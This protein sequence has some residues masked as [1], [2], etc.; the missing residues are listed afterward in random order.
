MA[1]KTTQATT[2]AVLK[3]CASAMSLQE[4]SS[5]LHGGVPERTLRRWLASW[6]EADQIVRLGNSRATRYRYQT[7]DVKSFKFL[8]GLDEDLKNSLLQQLRDLWTYTSTA[9]EGNT[10]TLGD[11]HFLLEEGLTVSGKP[12]K[13]HQE[14]IGH[15]RAIDLFYQSLSRP[16]NETIIFDLHKA[17]QTEVVAD[18]YKP[19]GAWKVEPNGVY[20]I[21]SSGQQA[22]IEY[23]LPKAVPILMDE[24]ISEVNAF[25]NAAILQEN[26]HRIYA[27]IH[28]GFAHI[29]PFWD[30]NGRL[31]R[32]L[33]NIPLL[34]AGLPPL[35]IPLEKRRNYIEVLAD[36]QIAIGQLDKHSGVWPDDSKLLAFESF[37]QSAYENTKQ[38]IGE[39]RSLQNKRE[40]S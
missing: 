25:D 7:V 13:D 22:Y 3:Q 17:V 24:L 40:T 30:G 16:L 15:A 36:Y 28:M 6:V 11:T 9:I 27:K 4:I 10:L 14:V 26:A 8:S 20:A 12:L 39:V 2:L 23:A 34:K 31:A 33:A 5:A 19:N 21:S 18:I 29:H 37:C 38:L 35:M 1:D 32:L